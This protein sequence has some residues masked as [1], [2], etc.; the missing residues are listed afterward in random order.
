MSIVKTYE[1]KG[2]ISDLPNRRLL[3][4]LVSPKRDN[5]LQNMSV[6]MTIISPGDKT[7]YA[8]HETSEEIMY[9]ISGRGEALIDGVKSKIYPDM[10]IS[11]PIASM[12]QLINTGDESL[13]LLWV[14]SP[15]GPEEEYIDIL[16]KIK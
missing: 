7:K 2:F 14:Y 15:S 13:K 12:H 6:G 5:E 3:K 9:I 8:A 4:V 16:K 10:L 11:L 1:K